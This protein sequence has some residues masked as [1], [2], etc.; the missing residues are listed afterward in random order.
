M[1]LKH[2]EL[3]GFKSFAKKERLDFEKRLTAIVGP[4]GSGKS[5]IAEA[6]RF[7]LGEQSMKSMRSKRTEDLLFNGSATLPR[8]NR[9]SVS[10]TF[11]NS[12]RLV[13]NA[14]DEIEIER[15]IHRDS[16]NEYYI[17]GSPVRLKDVTELLSE[18]KVGTAGH[19]IISQGEADRLLSMTARERKT[20]IEEALGLTQ[21]QNK[22]LEAEKKLA[23]TEENLESIKSLRRENAPHLQYLEREMK[24]IEKRREIIRE[25]NLKGKEYAKKF[26]AFYNRAVESNEDENKSLL[27]QIAEAEKK[28]SRAKKTKDD[29][30]ESVEIRTLRHEIKEVE[31]SLE[32]LRQE[33]GELAH[34]VGKLEAELEFYSEVNRSPTESTSI[35]NASQKLSE[36]KK[37]LENSQ[38]EQDVNKLRGIIQSALSVIHSDITSDTHEREAQARDAK[39]AAIEGRLEIL[40][41]KSNN[42][43][44]KEKVLNTRKQNIETDISTKQREAEKEKI[45]AQRSVYEMQALETRLRSVQAEAE[46]LKAENSRFYASLEEIALIANIHFSKED[47]SFESSIQ[48]IS[49]VEVDNLNREVERLKLKIESMPVGHAGEVERAYNEAKERAEFLDREIGDLEDTTTKLSTIAQELGHKIENEFSSGLKMIS[50]Y[51]STYFSHMFK[52]GGADLKLVE[53]TKRSEGEEGEGEKEFGVDVKVS[54]PHKLLRS[55]AMLSGGEKTLVSIAL[56]FALSQVNPPPFL[57]LDETDAALDEANSRRYGEA[58]KEL[59]KYSQLILITHNRETMSYASML[60]GITMGKS[61]SSELLSIDLEEAEKIAR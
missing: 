48:N 13:K 40:A 14:F 39:I 1:K 2:I 54:M 15:V 56:I 60:Y 16:T 44:E 23:K 30:A 34:S 19:H 17:N 57:I 6:F 26:T 22:K 36:V 51:F 42:L 4:N 33:K 20:H 12:D 24:L 59:S 47:L 3:R 11:D 21:Y 35:K 49:K 43:I 55:T 18:A 29:V 37:I 45:E 38:G 28:I 9:A 58:L 7:V 46:N 27:S 8:T 52:G 61:A 31:E 50:D 10:L 53:I 32:R 25:L 41:S 5:N